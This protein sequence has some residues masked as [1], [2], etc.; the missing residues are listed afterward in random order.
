MYSDKF[1]NAYFYEQMFFFKSLWQR[2]TQTGDNAGTL[3]GC[4]VSCEYHL[5]MQILQLWSEGGE[6]YGEGCKPPII[7]VCYIIVCKLSG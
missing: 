7:V 4:W 1:F 3:F 2:E 6:E 5:F